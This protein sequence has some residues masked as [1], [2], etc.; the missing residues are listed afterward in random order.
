M[1]TVLVRDSFFCVCVCLEMCTQQISVR[2]ACETN[3]SSLVERMNY[4]GGMHTAFF[5]KCKPVFSR[6]LNQKE[7]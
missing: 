1:K 5:M 7:L 4:L 2:F 3:A 6:D